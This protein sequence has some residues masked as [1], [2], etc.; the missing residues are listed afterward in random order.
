M[1]DH[2]D[3]PHR[4]LSGDRPPTFGTAESWDIA[5]CLDWAKA[6]GLPRP[7]AV[8]GESLGGMA[9]QR[10]IV[11]DKRVDHA[12]CI[13]PPGWPWDAIGKNVAWNIE[14][15]LATLPP[16]VRA[17]LSPIKDKA[18]Q[19]GQLINEAYGFDFL[20]DGNPR[21]HTA[22]PP[23]NPRILYIFGEDDPYEP[24]KA[25]QGWLHFYPG[26]PPGKVH[27]RTTPRIR[28]SLLPL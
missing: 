22:N 14:G 9:T 2:A 18:V 25:R 19:I 1:Y 3:I 10:L 12:V 20:N 15:I 6:N 16:P 5:A 17:V 27:G 4:G 26:R 11:E 28:E 21:C 7:F 24:E 13:H 23:G 8:M